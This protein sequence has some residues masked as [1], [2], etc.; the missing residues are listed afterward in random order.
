[1]AEADYRDWCGWT[2]LVER[3]G[4]DQTPTGADVIVGQVEAP[5]GSGNYTPDADS[6]EFDGKYMIRRSGGSAN[7]SSHATMVATRYYGNDGSMAP[8]VWFINCYEV[9]HWLQSGFLKVG[10]GAANP[11]AAPL[12]AQKL[13]NHAWVGSFGN[14]GTDH[15]ALRRL[16]WTIERDDSIVT[17]G[18]NNGSEGQ[19]LLAYGFNAMSV[20]KRDAAHAA[21]DVPSPYE[22]AGRMK[23]EITGPMGTTSECTAVVSAAS[24]ML[25]E[26][27]RADET[28]PAEG[29]SSETIKAI[30]MAGASHEGPGGEAGTWT[31]NAPQS[32]PDRGLTA[33]PLDEAVGAGHLNIDRSHQIMAGG[34]Q[35]GGTDWQGAT[36]AISYGW[37]VENVEPAVAGQVAERWWT[38]TLPDGASEVSVL[39]TWNRVVASSFGSWSM[40][41][42]DLELFAIDGGGTIPLIGDELSW[43]SGNVASTSEVDNVEHL[44]VEGL[45]PGTYAFR[46]SRVDEG[47]GGDDVA[48]AWWSSGEIGGLEGDLN[49]DGV[50]GV[51]DLLQML[52]AWGVCEGCVED[53]DGDGVVGVDDLLLM[54]SLWT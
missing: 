7:P 17:V 24:A 2:A 30:L 28:L 33:R 37:S 45:N 22:G 42:F 50:I 34:M 16:D 44:W 6:A 13:W 52:A 23:P 21:E 54:L 40:A 20:G 49:G 27:V 25:V 29:E 38:F 9:N 46:L 12:G 5:D 1:M 39:A 36:A 4:T 32:G 15:D 18:I 48:I 35:P 19:P 51:D 43:G 31:N 53:L 41:D 10:Q 3:V 8:G 26:M 47:S 14:T 11:P